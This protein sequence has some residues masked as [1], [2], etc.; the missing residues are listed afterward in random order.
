MFRTTFE[1]D[2][3]TIRCNFTPPF[4]TLTKRFFVEEC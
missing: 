2:F 1:V 4:Y 3:I